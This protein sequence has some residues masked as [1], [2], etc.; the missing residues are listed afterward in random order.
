M[1]DEQRED[2]VTLLWRYSVLN[3]TLDFE[4][5]QIYSTTDSDSLAQLRVD[6]NY[7]DHLDLF[8]GAD[9]FSGDD[10]GLFGQFDHSDR[11]STGFTLSF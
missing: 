4:W 5:Q 8:I 1:Y 11:I 6:Y 10:A 9:L 3:D 7:N 2:I